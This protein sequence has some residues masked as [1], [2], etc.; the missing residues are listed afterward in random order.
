MFT[1]T[2]LRAG[3]PHDTLR[4]EKSLRSQNAT[5]DR[6]VPRDCNYVSR[7]PSCGLCFQQIEH[8]C[9]AST[10]FHLG[11]LP[12][13]VQYQ[14]LNRIFGFRMAENRKSVKQDAGMF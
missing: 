8:T 11:K 14:S 3:T 10:V 9:F 7:H 1:L 13:H 2:V 6:A 12:V 4:P 5:K